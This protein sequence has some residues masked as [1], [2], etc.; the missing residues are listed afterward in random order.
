[1]IFLY[2]GDSLHP[3]IFRGPYTE[4]Q[5]EPIA[6]QELNL[7]FNKIHSLPNN[8]FEHTPYIHRLEIKYNPLKVLD[9][10]TTMAIGSLRMLDVSYFIL[11]L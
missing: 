4:T 9:V 6:L 8:L 10:S 2:S 11:E 3:E 1:M 7:S 5:Y